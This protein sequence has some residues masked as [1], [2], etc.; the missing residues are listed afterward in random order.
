MT[1][2]GPPPQSAWQRGARRRGPSCLVLALIGLALVAALIAALVVW[3]LNTAG[4]PIVID[5]LTQHSDTVEN[6]NYSATSGS[7]DVLEVTMRPEIT[8]EQA[9][10]F[11]C[12]VIG[13]LMDRHGEVAIVRIEN[14]SQGYLLVNPACDP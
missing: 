5:L 8:E 12:E 4:V 2:S 6:V 11:H 9:Q 7:D 3:L 13:S 14:A 10:A 1:D